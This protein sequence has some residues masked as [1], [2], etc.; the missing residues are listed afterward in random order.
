MGKKQAAYDA[1]GNIVAFYDT[2]DSPAP[3]GANVV[4]ITDDEWRTL[5]DG[6]AHGKRAVLDGNNRPSLIDPPAPT[7]DDVAASM[8]AKRD[9]AMDATDWLVSRH[10]DEKLIGSGTTITSAQFSALIK[11]RQALRDISGADGWPYI[12]LP[13]APDFVTAIA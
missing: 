9:S 2:V 6:Q 10:Q 11:Y 7:R 8:R 12:E 3:V 4:D 5:I 13:N 1:S